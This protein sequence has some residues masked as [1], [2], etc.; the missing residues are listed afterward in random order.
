MEPLV[1]VIL[2]VYNV[3]NYLSKCVDTVIGQTYKNIEII[4]VDDGSTDKSGEICDEYA[5]KDSR[6]KVIHQKNGGVSSA[7]N[8]GIDASRGDYIGFIDSDD[9]IDPDMY[10]ILL[11]EALS[12]DSDISCCLMDTVSIDGNV[13]SVIR[14]SSAFLSKERIIANFFDDGFIKSIA[15]S[16]CNKVYKKS[17]FDNLRFKP[18][19]YAEDILFIFEAVSL[20][21][22]MQ[23][24][25]FVGYHYLHRENSIMTSSFSKNRFDY[26]NA[27]RVIEAQCKANY[28]FAV[29]AAE[30]WVYYHVLILIREIVG[31]DLTGS[32]PDVVAK[33]KKYLKDNKRILKQLSFMRKMDYFGVMCCKPYITML[34]KV[35]GFRG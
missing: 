33:E 15:Y 27:A 34:F 7:R 35:K 21:T 16:P 19:K 32:F 30:R 9:A 25:D 23:F 6:V 20:T 2:P 10:S 18:Y 3:E 31:S 26:I 11:N 22:G 29:N 1:S 17:L 28:P 8:T 4:L 12:H 14:E 24:V 13:S 5:A